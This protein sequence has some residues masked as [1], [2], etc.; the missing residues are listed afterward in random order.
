MANLVTLN[1]KDLLKDRIKMQN[2]CWVCFSSV[3]GLFSTLYYLGTWIR[4]NNST[5]WAEGLRFVQFQKNSCCHRVLKNSPYSV[6]FGSEPKVG[7]SSTPL[8]P[9]IFDVIT[10]E[11]ELTAE[12]TLSNND[13][14][15]VNSSTDVDDE[16]NVNELK[17]SEPDISDESDDDQ[18]LNII[19]QKKANKLL[20]ERIQKTNVIRET[21]RA[22]QKRQADDFLNNTA[23]RHKF[24]DLNVGDNVVSK[25]YSN[26]LH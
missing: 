1:L 18:Q 16:L 3:I 22:G 7:L 25:V 14:I 10:T 12:L 13:V 4:E 17:I 8:N 26:A 2:Y 19:Q 11:E 6:L 21:A 24:A 15:D 9:S 5:K 20:T 23:K